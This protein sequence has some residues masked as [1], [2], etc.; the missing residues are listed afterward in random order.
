AWSS[1]ITTDA[2]DG[3]GALR[4]VSTGRGNNRADRIEINTF[5][6]PNLPSG[7]D[8]LIEF[9]AKWV[10]GEGVLL[11]AGY[12]HSMPKSHYL[13]VP[14]RL[15][16]PGSENSV[17]KRLPDGNLGPIIS[18]VHHSPALPRPQEPVNVR[19]KVSDSDGVAF[20][21]I[22]WRLDGTPESTIATIDML[23]D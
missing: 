2:K 16:T 21:R 22:E 18:G 6:P 8:L 7:K 19:A 9:D 5:N 17:H 10:V 23:D 3:T 4:I 11:T 15:G 13:K 14:E 12:N 20:V 1:R